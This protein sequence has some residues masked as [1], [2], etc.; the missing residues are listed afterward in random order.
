MTLES[1]LI[2]WRFAHIGASM[3]AFGVALFPLYAG[4][5]TRFP[6]RTAAVVALVSALLWFSCVLIEVAADPSSAFSPNEIRLVLFETSF[7]S[8][9]LAHLVLG[10]GLLAATLFKARTPV[11]ILSVLNLASLA[12]IGH[13]AAGAGPEHA[14]RLIAHVVHLGAGGIWL[15]GL[16][17]LWRALG[18]TDATQRRKLVNRFSMIGYGAVGLVILTGILNVRAITG[19]FI[20]SGSSPYGQ[21][22][23]LKLGLVGLLLPVALFNQF[24]ANRRKQWSTLSRGIAVELAIFTGILIVVSM[25]GVTPPM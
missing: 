21:L 7:G 13:A 4:V 11:A 14:G 19:A 24:Y 12:G 1:F 6:M 9:W 2:V 22:L 25:L 10:A 16:I 18:S 17:P 15:G 5:E 3:L 20:P 8:A 23:M